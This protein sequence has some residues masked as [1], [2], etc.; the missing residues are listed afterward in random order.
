MSWSLVAHQASPA[1][2]SD[3]IKHGLPLF[4]LISFVGLDQEVQL[5]LGGEAESQIPRQPRQSSYLSQRPVSIAAR[6][7]NVNDG[8]VTNAKMCGYTA[9]N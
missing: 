2:Q 6:E 8:L 5:S 4:V 3:S 1:Q 7:N 9:F